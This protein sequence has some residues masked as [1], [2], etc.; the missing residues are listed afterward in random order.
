VTTHMS[1]KKGEL[2]TVQCDERWRTIIQYLLATAMGKCVLQGS[3]TT[4]H[5]NLPPFCTHFC[6]NFKLDRSIVTS[7][8]CFTILLEGAGA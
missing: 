3:F 2:Y 8:V 7:Y 4:S 1:A 5:N 6:A